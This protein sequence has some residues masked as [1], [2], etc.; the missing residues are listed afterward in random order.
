MDLRLNLNLGLLLLLLPVAAQALTP[1]EREQCRADRAEAVQWHE[2]LSAEGA[3]LQTEGE[4]IEAVERGLE[5]T[6]AEVATQRTRLQGLRSAVEQRFGAGAV[7]DDGASA[8]E[9]DSGVRE[10][11]EFRSARKSF[12]T[13]VAD[14]NSRV[15]AQQA[16]RKDYNQRALAHNE[17]LA[18]YGARAA[19]IDARCA[20]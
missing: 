15:R 20:R 19:E 8:S 11:S 12:N 6:Q 10:I 14:Y 2:Q 1:A 5:Q 9:F 4:Q 16:R 18:R 3:R 13:L 7:V 17:Q